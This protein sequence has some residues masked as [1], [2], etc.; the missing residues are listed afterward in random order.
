MENINLKNLNREE[1]ENFIKNIINNSEDFSYFFETGIYGA[2][3]I[4]QMFNPENE[5]IIHYKV[6]V[7]NEIETEKSKTKIEKYLRT[8]K[9][10]YSLY[11]FY[12]TEIY[13]CTNRLLDVGGI[14]DSY[15]LFYLTKA[16][17]M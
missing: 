17:N 14:I 6:T 5:P 15:K 10:Q 3:T 4:S 9:Q 1:V 16:K 12:N 2:L 13:I 8:I 11:K 7:L